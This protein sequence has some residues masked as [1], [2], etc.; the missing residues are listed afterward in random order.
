MLSMRPL[1]PGPLLATKLTPSYECIKSFSVSVK[2]GDVTLTDT[3]LLLRST[4]H[5]LLILIKQETCD[6]KDGKENILQV[7]C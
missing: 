4:C 3:S 1:N 2:L 7:G 6:N 5:L